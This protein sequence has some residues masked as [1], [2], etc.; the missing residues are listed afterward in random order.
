MIYFILFLELFINKIW[1]NSEF[2]VTS[3]GDLG[4][5]GYEYRNNIDFNKTS[6]DFQYT[7]YSRYCVPPRVGNIKSLH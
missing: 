6:Q 4:K 5:A 2:K 7:V 3:S 1:N